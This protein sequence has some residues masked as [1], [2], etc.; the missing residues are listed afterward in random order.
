MKKLRF[1]LAC[2]ALLVAAL[3][4]WSIEPTAQEMQQ[5]KTKL[6]AL[7]TALDALRAAKADDDLIVDAEV[8]KHA[9]ELAL[10]FPEEFTDQSKIRQ[11][12][13]A[14]DHGLQRASQLKD[15]KPLWPD[16]KGPVSR[17]Y[18]SRVDGTAQPYRVIIPA[19]YN[20]SKPMPP[21]VY[22]HGRGD[23]DFETNWVGGPDKPGGTQKDGGKSDYIQLQAYGRFNVSFRWP[24]EIDV[25]EA[26]ASVKKRYNIDPD[27][28]VL[29]GFSMG[30]AG[31][32]QLG[33]HCPDQ[34]A[35]IEVDA[36]VLGTRRNTTGLSPAQ[37]AQTA[38]YG[39]MI[40]HAVN[41][42]NLPTVAYAG[43]NDKQLASSTSIREQLVREG[44]TIE[45]PSQFQWKGKDINAFFLAIPK[46]GH[47]H[48][49]GETSRL[50]NGFVAESIKRGRVTP[51]HLRFVTYTTRYHRHHW[52]TIDGLTQ[53]FERAEIDAVRDAAKVNFT[54]TTKNIARLIVT[55]TAKAEKITIDGDALE[56]EFKPAA[57]L[58]LVKDGGHWQV[59]DP[60][61]ITGLRKRH[62]LQGPIDDAFMD[63]FLYV[64]PTGKAFDGFGE[65]YAKQ[66]LAGFSK[67]FAKSYRG[68]VRTKPDTAITA[69]D[70]AEHNLILFGD[71]GSNK[72]LAQ[73]LEKLP[74]K[75]TEKAIELAGKSYGTSSH[76]PVMVYPNPLNPN[77][78]VVLNA[79]LSGPGPGAPLSSYGDYAVLNI[80]MAAEAKVGIVAHI[81][82]SGLFDE[83]WKLPGRK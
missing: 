42:F 9:V 44:F 61:A 51:D 4:A 3:P 56:F 67:A 47:A 7:D 74:L 28:V 78:Y 63:S 83:T 55:D 76:I 13:S 54:I 62:G 34:F 23:T 65:A 31:A 68:E 10:R 50:V 25:L 66:A 6:A 43:E 49:S 19:S 82:D 18:R 48:A 29:A 17:A 80:G 52:I 64:T 46:A 1:C 71:P 79:G 8:A 38:I 14:L 22:L 24:G 33:L 20:K 73:I 35:A 60:A 5:I 15:G 40:D 2:A 81:A 39:L 75:W 27:R 26:I 11:A 57:R 12:L 53:H 30:G 45:H 77:R 41:T 70:T 72:I 59:A 36:G 37:K 58:L 69:A 16:L 32:W 21:Y